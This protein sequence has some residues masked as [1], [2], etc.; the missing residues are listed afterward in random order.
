[1][2]QPALLHC[3]GWPA[4]SAGLLWACL[5]PVSAPAGEKAGY[6]FEPCE[7]ATENGKAATD[8]GTR[9]PGF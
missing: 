7:S 2:S 5:A 1:M 8:C 6:I 4:S 3:R 9:E